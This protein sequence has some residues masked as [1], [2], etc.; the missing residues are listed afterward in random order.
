LFESK[1]NLNF[2]CLPSNYKFSKMKKITI[3]IAI[4]ML[5]V[6]WS[7]GQYDSKKNIWIYDLKT[8][9]EEPERTFNLDLSNHGLKEIPLELKELPNL[10]LLKLSDNN[11]ESLNGRLKHLKKLEY[12]EL[13]GNKIA[14][15]DFIEFEGSFH[16]LDELWL[17]DNRLQS[18]DTSLNELTNITTLDLG[19][20]QISGFDEDIELRRLIDFRVDAN[21]LIEVPRF[22]DKSIKLHRLNINANRIITFNFKNNF[23]NIRVLNI[24]DNPIE[25]I[26]WGS[27]RLKLVYLIL[28][29]INI[30]LIDLKRIPR[31]VEILSLENCGVKNIEDLM[32][33]RNIKE[34][35][36]LKNEIETLPKE[37]KDLKKLKKNMVDW[38]SIN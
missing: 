19:N 21:H 7:Y 35:S 31:T 33:L 11:I 25:K 26:E 28:D 16:T 10:R 8:A 2:N 27:Q 1:K 30:E 12:V 5:S 38:K 36:L 18:I 34:L 14:E 4:Q 6:L 20:N 24:G 13:S 22:L 23:R 32:H 3:C 29:W 9:L 37:I 15:L 17:R